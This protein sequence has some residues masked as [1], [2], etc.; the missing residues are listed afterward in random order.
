MK[1]V[2]WMK[3]TGPTKLETKKIILAIKTQSHKEIKTLWFF[4]LAIITNKT[5][6]LQKHCV[7]V[8]SWLKLCIKI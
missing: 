3:V 7:L 2:I 8:P 6:Y 1:N 4:L 5:I